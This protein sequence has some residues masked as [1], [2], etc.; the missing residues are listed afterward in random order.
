MNA[1]DA[2]NIIKNW[3]LALKRVKEKSGR[4]WQS[5]ADAACV[6]KKTLV[7]W[8]AGTSFP[9]LVTF[10]LYLDALGLELKIQKKPKERLGCA[11]QQDTKEDSPATPETDPAHVTYGKWINM[12]NG[13]AD[14]SACGRHIINVYDDDNADRF[15]RCCGAK[16]N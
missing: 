10:M 12:K 15:C 16:M 13:N 11:E 1:Q 3:M 5:I 4:S 7:V 2:M 14:C 6:R 9:N 8:T